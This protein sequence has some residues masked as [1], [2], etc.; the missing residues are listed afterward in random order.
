M[1][2]ALRSFVQ[3]G[4]ECSWAQAPAPIGA[5]KKL[6]RVGA[7]HIVKAL[8]EL[9]DRWLNPPEWTKEEVLEFPGTVG[10]PWTRLIAN[11]DSLKPGDVATVQ[12]RRLVPRD[13]A[14]AAQLARRTLTNLYN[15]RPEWLNLAHRRLDEAV[16]AAYGWSADLSPDAVLEKLLALNLERAGA[17]LPRP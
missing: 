13:D 2:E 1:S 15:Q 14:C 7:A 12:Y 6:Q 9:R 11:A 10:G 8:C 17:E 3:T 16:A 4:L 5:G